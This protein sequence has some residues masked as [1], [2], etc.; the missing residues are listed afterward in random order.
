MDRTQFEP[1]PPLFSGVVPGPHLAGYGTRLGGYLLDDLIL[2]VTSIVVLIPFG[3]AFHETTITVGKSTGHFTHIG[4]HGFGIVLQAAVI[5]LYGTLFIGSRRGQTPGMMIVGIRCVS[6]GAGTSLG[7]G[8]AFL[9][10]L[11]EFVLGVLVIPWV[12]DML[13]PLWDRRNQT[14]HD[15]S[16]GC[17]VVSGD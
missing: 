6:A 11:V 12:I 2:L 3:G 13:F 14:I 1:P 16:V 5:L 17:L 4:P 15:K 9:R 7:H 8:K 10:A